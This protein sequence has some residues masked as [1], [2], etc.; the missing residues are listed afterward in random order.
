MKYIKRF[1]E[2]FSTEKELHIEV[3]VDEILDYLKRNCI[4][5]WE[6]IFIKSE[7]SNEV[8]DIIDH[9]I[10]DYNDLS[11]IKFWVCLELNDLNQLRKLLPE[12]EEKEEYEKCALIKN[13]LVG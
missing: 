5:N 10:E 11:D 2:S 9:Y 12:L 13:K 1:N 6:D 3:I 4:D 8:N 7:H